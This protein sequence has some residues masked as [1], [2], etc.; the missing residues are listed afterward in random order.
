[1][2]SNL[3][4]TGRIKCGKSTLIKQEITPYLD[5]VGGYFVQRLFLLRGKLWL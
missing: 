2:T 3:F 1:M 5:D 4:L